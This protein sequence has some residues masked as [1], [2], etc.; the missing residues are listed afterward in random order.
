MPGTGSGLDRWQVCRHPACRYQSAYRIVARHAMPQIALAISVRLLDIMHVVGLIPT[1][2]SIPIGQL[3]DLIRQVV[4][5][6]GCSVNLDLIPETVILRQ[7]DGPC[8]V[9]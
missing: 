9:L 8:R 3:L 2:R 6:S 7:E 5:Q 4:N 1:T